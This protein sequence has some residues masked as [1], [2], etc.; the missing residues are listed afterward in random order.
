MAEPVIQDVAG[1]QL[2]NNTF[3]ASPPGSQGIADN[4]VISQKG[5]G[6]P[7]NGQAWA[8]AF[9][10]TTQLPYQLT[11]FQ[12]TVMCSSAP[13]KTSTAYNLSSLPGGGGSVSPYSGG[14]YNPVD[15]NGSNAS[16]ARMKF[17][18]A[19]QFLYFCTQN[20]G[21]MAL[22]AIGGTPRKAGLPRMPD[23]VGNTPFI[24][25]NPG[26]GW[27]PY[28]SSVAY[29]TVLKRATSTGVP[30]LSP[31]SNRT[32]VTNRNLVPA[33]AITRSGTTVTAVFNASNPLGSTPL[34]VG[35]QF[36]L[37]PGEANFPAGAYTVTGSVLSGGIVTMTWSQGSGAAT[38]TLIQDLSPSISGNAAPLGV[39][40]EIFLPDAAKAGDFVQI[41]RS[42]PT[43]IS[44]TT[45]SD[46]MFQTGEVQLASAD[47]A[48][49]HI[50]F[51]DYTPLGV[52][53]NPLYTNPQTGQGATAINFAPPQYRDVANFDS[54]VWYLNSTSQ[55]SF[56][57]EMLGVG[58]VNGVQNGDTLT[59][60]DIAA[61]GSVNVTLTFA[62]AAAPGQ[63]LITTNG[64]ASYNIQW[65]TNYLTEVSAVNLAGT[66]IRLYQ[67]SG[68]NDLPGKIL[69]QRSDFGPQFTVQVSRPG[70]WSPGF[71]TSPLASDN[72]RQPNGLWNS[73]L[74]QP[75]SVPLVNFQ[76]VG[77][78]SYFGDRLLGLRNGLIICKEGDGI[79]AL[80]GSG[81]NYT[82]QQIS[83]ANIIAPDCAAV[84]SDYAWVYTDQGILRVSAT[85][86][87]SVVSRPIETVLNA[88]ASMFPTSTYSDSFCVPYETERRIMFY[89]PV[90]GTDGASPT[91]QA[92]CYSAATNAWTKF[93]AVAMSGIV[94][95]E[96]YL[97]LGIF[98]TL[99]KQPRL[100]QERKTQTYL[101][102]A[103]GQFAM[104]VIAYPFN[105]DPTLIQLNDSAGSTV[106]VVGSIAKGFGL[107]QFNGATTWATKIAAVRSD[108]GPGVFQLSEIIPW[109]TGVRAI[110]VYQ[111]Y[112]VELQWLPQGSPAV[113]QVLTRLAEFFK[114]GSFSNYYGL[115]TLQTDQI[116]SEL[117]IP[118]PFLGFGLTQF[119]NS[120]F[121]NPTPQVVDVNPIDSKWVNA[122]QYSIGFL[123]NEVWPQLKIQGVYAQIDRALAP[124]GRG[125]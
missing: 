47:I 117:Q 86:G 20:Y 112:Q 121:G 49:G 60:S 75:E 70:S 91:M 87:V 37:S 103:D 11:E 94:T 120:P 123:L 38:S 58:A 65:T 9:I 46:E 124:V 85:G 125:Q 99:F 59:I 39:S 42:S 61:G 109:T 111:P 50:I 24:P 35:S 97:W 119:G 122:A 79:W 3:S 81:G 93:N 98:D 12:Q 78:K 18:Q 5:I 77:S 54:Q 13:S 31:P 108:L 101:D 80:T 71:G 15:D 2:S 29:R 43:S 40:P 14:P 10:D 69:I 76:T 64:N 30:L 7:R 22:E 8:G 96:H 114:P 32:T 106:L 84:F 16:Y 1:L 115:T 36:L 74:A 104:D 26:N 62:T 25:T 73:K 33:Q 45:P 67:N 21:P 90:S 27:L 56:S 6:Q 19:A 89:V 51:N 68:P 92:F 48:A 82:L 110:Q 4:I 41:Y 105:G 88:L 107:T 113:R 44:T 100:T 72:N 17:C 66:G 63:M 57:M 55:H 34:P 52:P 28:N 83:N 102:Y 53:N 23:F 118:T 95:A 116:Q